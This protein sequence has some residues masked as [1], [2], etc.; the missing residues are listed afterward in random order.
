MQIFLPITLLL[1]KNTTLSLYKYVLWL[2][3]K[4]KKTLSKIV[5]ENEN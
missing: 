5:Y 2:F 4:R 3:R 1:C